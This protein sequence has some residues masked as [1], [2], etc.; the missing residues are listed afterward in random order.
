MQGSISYSD[1]QSIS[2]KTTAPQYQRIGRKKRKGNIVEDNNGKNSYGTQKCV[3]PAIVSH[4]VHTIQYRVNKKGPSVLRGSAARRVISIPMCNQSTACTCTG[5]FDT[6]ITSYSG[7][8][9]THLILYSTHSTATDKRWAMSHSRISPF[10]K[11]SPLTIRSSNL[12]CVSAAEHHTAE[13][14]SKTTMTKLQKLLPRSDPSLNNFLNFL[15][16]PSIWEAAVDNEQR[17]IS[18]VVLESN[19]TPYMSRSSDFFSTVPSAAL[20]ATWGPP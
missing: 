3:R 17:C 13:Q 5:T 10:T 19:V 20:C 7:C 15:K 14:Y 12:R 18:N 16:I 11:L 2:P 1:L 8:I 9:E 6:G 4:Q